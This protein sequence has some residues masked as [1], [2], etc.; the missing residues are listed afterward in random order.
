MKPSYTLYKKVWEGNKGMRE[1]LFIIFKESQSQS[2][3]KDDK[4]V[5]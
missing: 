2:V 4:V 1:K 5:H 3:S